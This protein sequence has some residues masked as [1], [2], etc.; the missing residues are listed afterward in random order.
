MA[1]LENFLGVLVLRVLKSTVELSS[2]SFIRA[3]KHRWL[4]LPWE[5]SGSAW[6]FCSRYMTIDALISGKFQD[7]RRIWL[8]IVPQL[9]ELNWHKRSWF[10]ETFESWN[11][12]DLNVWRWINRDKNVWRK[13]MKENLIFRIIRRLVQT[14]TRIRPTCRLGLRRLILMSLL[15]VLT[16]GNLTKILNLP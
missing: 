10:A 2:V 11:S 15:L 6:Y 8:L 7:V 13:A 12:E 4:Y 5:A 1:K 3:F 9:A 16:V 14:K